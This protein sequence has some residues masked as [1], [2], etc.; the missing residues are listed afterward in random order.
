MPPASALNSRMWYHTR[1]ANMRQ[2]RAIRKAA[3]HLATQHWN[4]SKCTQDA[5]SQKNNFLR[6]LTESKH[7]FSSS[8]E[9]TLLGF[10]GGWLCCCWRVVFS[11]MNVRYQEVRLNQKLRAYKDCLQAFCLIVWR[12]MNACKNQSSQAAS[13]VR[14]PV[15]Y[16]ACALL[17]ILVQTMKGPSLLVAWAAWL[18]AK[19]AHAQ[20]MTKAI[21]KRI[22]KVASRLLKR[23]KKGMAFVLPQNDFFG[24]QDASRRV[25]VTEYRK[26]IECFGP[27]CFF[28]RMRLF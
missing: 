13:R 8:N 10:Y 17:N 14:R 5:P 16:G 9:P 23:V 20:S 24:G 4:S 12:L 27:V 6:C 28:C 18:E 1:N 3:Q 26:K 22:F 2:R 19:E 7:L 21:V 11:F 15:L 25:F